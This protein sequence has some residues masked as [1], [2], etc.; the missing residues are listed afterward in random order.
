MPLA[1]ACHQG[2]IIYIGSFSKI[3]DPSLRIGFMLAS[4]NFII[5]CIA[6]RKIID[7]GGDGYMQNALATLIEEG[8]LKR[9]LN[10]AQKIYHQRRDFF[11]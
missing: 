7:V 4:Q 2:N 1:S 8:E 9:H 5:Q 10:K 6:L 11:R 3:L